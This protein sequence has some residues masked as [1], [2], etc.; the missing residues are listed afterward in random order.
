ME[1]NKKMILVGFIVISRK[2][3]T[4]LDLLSIPRE[5]GE[6]SFRNNKSKYENEI[7]TCTDVQ[8]I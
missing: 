3:R 2:T 1:K 8:Y 4:H 6:K 7:S 5:W